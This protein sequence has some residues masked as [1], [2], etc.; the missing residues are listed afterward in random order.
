MISYN[1]I[2]LV[3][4]ISKNLSLICVAGTDNGNTGDP[5]L[6]WLTTTTRYHILKN[7][8]L[9][10]KKMPEKFLTKPYETPPVE[11]PHPGRFFIDK[12]TEATKILHVPPNRNNTL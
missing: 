11:A 4:C 10:K 5:D 8:G 6:E 7:T 12:F 9:L 2:I 3:I 1:K